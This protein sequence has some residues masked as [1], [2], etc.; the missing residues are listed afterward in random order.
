MQLSRCKK[1]H[2]VTVDI[3]YLSNNSQSNL[4]TMPLVKTELK[5]LSIESGKVTRVCKMAAVYYT[6]CAVLH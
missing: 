6:K 1:N 3:I 4:V 5:P 2:Y